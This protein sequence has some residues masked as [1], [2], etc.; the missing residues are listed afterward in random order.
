MKLSSKARR[1]LAVW[2]FIAAASLA[3]GSCVAMWTS[4]RLGLRVALGAFVTLWLGL[5]AIGAGMA[6]HAMMSTAD[7][8]QKP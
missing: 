8:E 2:I 6:I 3:L 4:V 7:K 1:D 5:I